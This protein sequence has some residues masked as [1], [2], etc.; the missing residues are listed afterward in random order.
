MNL[1][2]DQGLPPSNLPR[3]SGGFLGRYATNPSKLKS[4]REGPP[5]DISQTKNGA[6]TKLVVDLE[7]ARSPTALERRV[8]LDKAMA[9]ESPY[10]YPAFN[11][12]QSQTVSAFKGQ[13][14]GNGNGKKTQSYTQKN[15]LVG[16]LG[17]SLLS[18][19]SLEALAKV[20]SKRDHIETQTEPLLLKQDFP[21]ISSYQKWSKNNVDPLLRDLR[22]N[23]LSQRPED[24]GLYLE[25]Y[26]K[27]L[28]EGKDLPDC[29][30]PEEIWANP[31]PEST[32]EGISLN[33]SVKT[34]DVSNSHK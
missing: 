29:K 7:R 14:Q 8:V 2:L 22:K 19:R 33:Q 31:P 13:L 12:S 15:S 17:G 18:G 24:L 23:L 11:P 21:D 3:T 20:V 9:A 27:A 25:A 4:L 26:G 10:P 16:G 34:L 5:L 1:S 28:C 30:L 32:T 6:S